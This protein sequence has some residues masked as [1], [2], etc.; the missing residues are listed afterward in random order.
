MWN[1]YKL[2]NALYPLVEEVEPLQAV[3]NEYETIYLAKYDAMMKQKLGLDAAT[4]YAS[5]ISELEKTLQ[6]IETDYTIFFRNLAS[7]LQTDTSL[8]ALGKIMES[9]YNIEE[10][11]SSVK[12]KWLRW[13]DE[14]IQTIQ[15]QNINDTERAVRMNSVNPKYVLR[16]Y[17]AQLAID[18]ADKGNYDVIDELYQLLKQPYNEQPTYE[19]WFAKRPEWARH[20]VGCSMLSCS[21]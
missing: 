15:K 10:L 3:L 18:E 4:D 2:A 17:I 14:Y 6:L 5:L 20:K 9:F 11:N 21:S 7:V 13:F 1:L 12:E 16:N 8:E 19:K